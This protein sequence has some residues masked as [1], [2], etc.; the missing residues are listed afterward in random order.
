[1]DK[2][3]LDRE[4]ALALYRKLTTLRQLAQKVSEDVKHEMTKHAISEEIFNFD[5]VEAKLFKYLTAGEPDVFAIENS[6]GCIY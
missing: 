6:T 3:E 1:M 2:F 4:E 5:K